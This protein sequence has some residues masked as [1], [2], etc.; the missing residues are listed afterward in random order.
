MTTRTTLSL[1]IA[2]V[3]ATFALAGCKKPVP[4]DT[5]PSSMSTPSSMTTPSTMDSAS[6]AMTAAS[7]AMGMAPGASAP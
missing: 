1:G 5:T 3:A 7:S 6:S 2:L 4:A